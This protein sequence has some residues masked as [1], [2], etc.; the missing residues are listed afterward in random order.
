MACAKVRYYLQHIHRVNYALAREAV[1]IELP[2][3]HDLRNTVFWRGI[4]QG[5]YYT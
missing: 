3:V 2:V 4:R 5:P 1:R